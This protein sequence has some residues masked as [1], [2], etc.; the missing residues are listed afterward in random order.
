VRLWD[1]SALLSLLL[2]QRATD[3]LKE[4]LSADPVVVL[5]WGTKVEAV[6]A[7]SRLTRGDQ[8]EEREASRVLREIEALTAAAF[9]VQPTEEVRDAACRLLRV[10]ELRAADALQ[11]AA[12]LV[13]TQQSPAGAGFVCLD[14]RLRQAADREGFE[15]LP[16]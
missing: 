5:W 11:L 12:A 1:T 15:V 4:I 2:A 9:E 6:S 13:W 10:H 3:A 7:L 16:A 8:L 14:R